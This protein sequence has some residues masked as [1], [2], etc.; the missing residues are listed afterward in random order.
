MTPPRG[1]VFPLV[2]IVGLLAVSTFLFAGRRPAPPGGPRILIDSIH[3][4]NY[5]DAGLAPGV[6]DYHRIHSPHALCA[7]LAD[8]GIIF[9]EIRHGRLDR[10]TL[11]GVSALFLNLVSSNLPAFSV[12]EIFAVRDF[13]HDG[14]SL[15]TIIDHS[16][17]YD[18]TFKLMPLFE[19]L[20]IELYTETA[21][22]VPPR[23]IGPGNGWIF[24]RDFRPHPITDGLKQVAFQTGGT[25]DSRF[26]VATISERG[27]GDQWS[28]VDYGEGPRGNYGNWTRDEGE[29]T[30]RLGTILAKRFGG[31]RI[32]VIADQNMIGDVWLTYADNYKLILN[33]YAWLLDDPSLKDYGRFETWRQ[34]R[35]LLLEDP[36]N[37]KFGISTDNGFYNFRAGLSRHFWTFTRGTI[38]DLFDLIV[39][40]PGFLIQEEILARAHAQLSQGKA[41]LFLGEGGT[42]PPGSD[43]IIDRAAHEYAIERDE[44]A[45][46]VRQ[47]RLG[48]G[49]SIIAIPHGERLNGYQ[50]EKPTVNPSQEKARRLQRIVQIIQEHLPDDV[51]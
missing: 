4:H 29:R 20:D 42:L 50:L 23:T 24:I 51:R 41:L 49:A 28:R 8:R 9:T 22:D 36:A 5:L 13:V 35:V 6:Y 3:A 2:L 44:T 48:N 37:A 45:D 14:G 19:Q 38:D 27:W 10:Q 7:Y 32:V 34:P 11:S 39:F 26:A 25:V 43:G 12:D 17:A 18:H 16:N 47:I 15:L 46:E 40:P 30:G 31:G 1:A 33:T 21:C